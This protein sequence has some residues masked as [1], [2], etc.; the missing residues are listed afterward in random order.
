M[1]ILEDADTHCVF[2]EWHDD[3]VVER[4][5][6]A[7]DLYAFH[8]VKTRA[9]SQ[10]PWK[11][12]QLFGLGS[13]KGGKTKT[14][15]PA[16]SDSIIAKLLVHQENFSASCRKAVFVTN[17]GVDQEVKDFTESIHKTAH[18]SGLTGESL[19]WFDE[20]TKAFAQT[21]SNI[22]PDRIFEFLKILHIESEVGSTAE[23]DL[24]YFKIAKRILNLSEIDLK[25]SEAISI[26]QEL[27]DVVRRKSHMTI[28]SIPVAEDLLRA[29]KGVT[30]DDVL[31]VL[32]LSPD[33]YREL[34]KNGGDKALLTL[35]RL[36]RLCRRSGVSETL[37]MRFCQLK[38][39]WDIWFR[40]AQHEGDPVEFLSLRAECQRLLEAH[41][42]RQIDFTDLGKSATELANQFSSRLSTSVPLSNALVLGYI[43]ALAAE[44]GSKL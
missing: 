31:E 41:V 1:T 13:P 16:H 2:C 6:T 28:N 38:S 10:G 8:Q 15:P 21:F 18:R 30:E 12:R 22:T 19:K 35:S 20:I 24:N 17:A 26:G 23:L 32:T 3:Y 5:T 4:K 9:A 29:T 33:A 42:A 11:M 36:H 34:K 44:T 27:V 37:I 14:I 40:S 25:I 43:L 39:D 7:C